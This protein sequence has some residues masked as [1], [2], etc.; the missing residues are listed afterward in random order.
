MGNESHDFLP[1]DPQPGPSWGRADWRSASDDLTVALDPTQ[2]QAAIKAAAKGAG[3][4]LDGRAVEEAAA[5]S[6]RAMMLIRTYRVR[7]HLA[8]DL[9]PLGLSHQVK[10][11]HAQ[12]FLTDGDKI[13]VLI[14]L[15][16]REMEHFDLAIDLMN[17]FAMGL[18]E[19]A[20]VTE[21][22]ELENKHVKMLLAPRENPLTKPELDS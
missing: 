20:L 8:A 15:R 10:L 18:A 2:M 1:D 17:R 13:K 22:P 5:D 3:A 12:K 16:G 19:I 9:D 4:Q 21:P 14:V 6:I 11:K 7:G